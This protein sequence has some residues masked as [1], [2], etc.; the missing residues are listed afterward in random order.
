MMIIKFTFYLLLYD[1]FST[2]IPKFYCLS[3]AGFFYFS[4]CVTC[5]VQYF[6]IY[7]LTQTTRV[8]CLRNYHPHLK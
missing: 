6:T 1:G 4:A 8:K 5:L 2:T 3:I 7:V